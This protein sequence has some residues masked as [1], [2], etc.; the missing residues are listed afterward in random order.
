MQDQGPAALEAAGKST[1]PPA[2][3]EPTPVLR[4]AAETVVSGNPRDLVFMNDPAHG[5]GAPA[6]VRSAARE[7]GAATAASSETTLDARS[8]SLPTLA[9]AQAYQDLA[10]CYSQ[11]QNHEGAF[12][13]STEAIRLDPDGAAAYNL[14]GLVH[15]RKGDQELAVT[16]FNGAL[17]CDPDCAQAYNNRGLAR[18]SQGDYRGAIADYSEVIRINP[19]DVACA[20]NN[21]GLAH[22]SLGADEAAFED[23]T[24]SITRDPNYAIAYCNRAL[25]QFRRRVPEHAIADCTAA[26]HIDPSMALAY[27]LRGDIYQRMGD[28]PRAQ[29]DHEAVLRFGPGDRRNER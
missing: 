12:A 18:A 9:N 29:A 16:D 14:R 6:W 23:L 3:V 22:A 7:V 19:P 10:R 25:V 28:L 8:S 20:Y 2:V 21:R 4:I 17:A 26:L 11:Q 13:A 5:R 27:R 1:S 24:E 15:L